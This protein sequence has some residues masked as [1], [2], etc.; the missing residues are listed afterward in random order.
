MV[1]VPQVSWRSHSADHPALGPGESR[2]RR[3]AGPTK[4]LEGEGQMDR[5]HAR[6]SR[7][8]HI[9][10]MKGVGVE[11]REPVR[12]RV[13]APEARIVTMKV[14]ISVGSAPFEH[15]GTAAERIEPQEAVARRGLVAHAVAVDIVDQGRRNMATWVMPSFPW[16]RRSR[17]EEMFT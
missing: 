17:H 6:V 10:D 11:Y 7:L 1:L 15:P 16:M 13:H 3:I 12:R 4:S 5:S 14:V 2:Q 8:L 9:R